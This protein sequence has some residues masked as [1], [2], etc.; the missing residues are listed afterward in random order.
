MSN[1]N[2]KTLE[3]TVYKLQLNVL[4]VADIT[5]YCVYGSCKPIGSCEKQAVVF[6]VGEVTGNSVEM[7]IPALKSGSYQYQ[8]FIRRTTTNQEFMVL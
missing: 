1:T 8:V 6:N 2:I 4:N 7:Y 5:E 3:G